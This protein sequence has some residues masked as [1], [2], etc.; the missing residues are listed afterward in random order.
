MADQSTQETLKI[1]I[2][3]SPRPYSNNAEEIYKWFC[4]SLGIFENID[5][6]K[7]ASSVFR[8]LF[9]L[10]RKG[11]KVSSTLLAKIIGMSRG[12]VINHL[13]NLIERGLVVKKGRFYFVRRLSFYELVRELEEEVDTIFDRMQK[14]AKQL[15]S[16]FDDF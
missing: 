15:D 6:S 5:K 1:I 9:I 7:V 11:E 13:N 8:T 2:R 14:L 4:R 16:E 3:K 12:S 10:N